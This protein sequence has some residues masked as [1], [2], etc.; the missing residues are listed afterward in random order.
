MLKDNWRMFSVKNDNK[1][2][3]DAEILELLWEVCPVTAVGAE[4]MAT[5]HIPA[6]N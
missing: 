4:L 2:I 3:S 6:L 5:R 1:T